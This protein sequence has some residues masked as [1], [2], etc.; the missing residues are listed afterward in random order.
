MLKCFDKI[1]MI[2]LTSEEI[3]QNYFNT[4]GIT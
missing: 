4:S 3:A 1:W 2:K